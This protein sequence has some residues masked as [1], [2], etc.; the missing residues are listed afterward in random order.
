MHH[1]TRGRGGNKRIK[2]IMLGLN[3]KSLTLWGDD[4]D[5]NEDADNS[6]EEMMTTITMKIIGMHWQNNELLVCEREGWEVENIRGEDHLSWW[7]D[8][9]GIR[10]E[11]Y[12]QVLGK[13]KT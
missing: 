2:L 3:K 4:G 12:S 7:T 9:L 5:D 8:D 1:G 13:M 10:R 11:D 6:D